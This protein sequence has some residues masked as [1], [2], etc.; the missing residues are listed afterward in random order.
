AADRAARHRHRRLVRRQPPGAEGGGGAGE[1]GET[2]ADSGRDA[3]GGSGEPRTRRPESRQGARPR[4]AGFRVGGHYPSERT[5][6]ARRTR[7][8]CWIAA[9]IAVKF[10]SVG[11]PS[12]DSMRCRLFA[13]LPTSIASASKPMVALTSRRSADLERRV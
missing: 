1:E 2:E 13:G 11:L 9:R 12:S 6:T 4:G 7:V 8:S 5:L 10:S 3:R